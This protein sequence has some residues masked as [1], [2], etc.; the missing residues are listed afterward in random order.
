MSALLEMFALTRPKIPKFGLKIGSSKMS[1]FNKVL[2]TIFGLTVTTISTKLISYK[3]DAF[4]CICYF[5]CFRMFI[6]VL[7][8][9]SC[10]SSSL[11]MNLPSNSKKFSTSANQKVQEYQLHY[12]FSKLSS[13]FRISS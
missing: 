6:D 1:Q 9:T 8:T 12:R 4:V 7:C 10:T 11:I 3:I 5:F 13:W 2:I